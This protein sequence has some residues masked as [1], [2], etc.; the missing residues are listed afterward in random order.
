M[1]NIKYILYIY[2]YVYNMP[3]LH[4][5]CAYVLCVCLRDACRSLC[6]GNDPEDRLL[7]PCL[8]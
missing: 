2:N 7:P 3:V 8:C 5:Q 4:S 1:L 6:H